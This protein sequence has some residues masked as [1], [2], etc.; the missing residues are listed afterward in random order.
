MIRKLIMI[1]CLLCSVDML[2]QSRYALKYEPN[3]LPPK[4]E[5]NTDYA[6]YKS[7]GDPIPPFKLVVL[8]WEETYF[9][10]EDGKNVSKKREISP[11]RTVT[12]ADIPAGKTPLL[13]FF[14]PTCGHC[15]EQTL[16]F[17]AHMDLFKNTQ[18]I[19][20]ASPDV[21]EYLNDFAVKTHLNEYPQIWV[22]MDY[23]NLISKAYTYNAL[24]QLCIYDNNYRL[25]KILSGGSEIDSLKQYLY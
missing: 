1:A 16:K 4:P 14:N 9:E 10:Q 5:K 6:S 3:K 11:L 7:P 19:L 24:P 20:V 2:A 21:G 23:D 17:Q 22:G 13:M 12:N 18:I 25:V 8:P 15:E